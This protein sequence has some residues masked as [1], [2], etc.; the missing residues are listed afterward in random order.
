V[1][2]AI[3]SCANAVVKTES[4][5]CGLFPTTPFPSAVVPNV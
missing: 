5:I 1:P 4:G 3:S 2:A